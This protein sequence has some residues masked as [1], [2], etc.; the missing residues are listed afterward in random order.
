MTQYDLGFIDPN[1]TSGVELAAMLSNFNQALRSA[2][3]GATRP[4]YAERGTM[5][6]QDTGAAVLNLF[7]YDGVDDILLGTINTTTNIYTSGVP[8]TLASLGG[9]PAG[10]SLT[11]GGSILGGGNLTAD[12]GLY[13]KGDHDNPPAGHYY[14][15]NASGTQ[16]FHPL[17]S[18]TAQVGQARPSVA[19]FVPGVQNFIVPSG[20][21]RIEFIAFAGGGGQIIRNFYTYIRDSDGTPVGHYPN[22]TVYNYQGGY[23]NG[24]CGTLNVTPGGSLTI[25]VGNSGASNTVNNYEGSGAGYIGASRGGD[26]VIYLPGGE[27]FRAYGGEGA[28]WN[29]GTPAYGTDGGLVIQSGQNIS[30]F[31]P[32]LVASGRYVAG[33]PG[34]HGLVHLTYWS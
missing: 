29:D 15:T 13:L 14:G 11:T 23:G 34:N 5:W 32:Q 27:A 17:T 10:R 6:V 20:V 16:G 12:R 19:V 4:A 21:T 3:K 7:F 8:V 26:T 30:I 1:E 33:A 25:E 24:C 9:V 28:M 22:P 31:A 2:H 18:V